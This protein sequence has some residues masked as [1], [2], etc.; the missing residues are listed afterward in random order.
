MEQSVDISRL[1]HV[2]MTALLALLWVADVMFLVFSI[3]SILTEGPTV[4]IMFASEV[5]SL[6]AGEAG[7]T[8]QYMIL[9]ATIWSI[10]MKYGINV[11]DLRAEEVWE[12]KSM[13]VFYVDLVTG[14]FSSPE[15]PP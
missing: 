6:R 14:A 13:F 5:R 3:E 9:V 8:R 2:R 15:P 4:M 7:L 10:S 1:F 12:E 11:V